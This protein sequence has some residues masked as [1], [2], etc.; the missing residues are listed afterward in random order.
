MRTWMLEAPGIENLALKE[1]DTPEPGP[2]QVRLRMTAACVNFR[3]TVIA[4]TGNGGELPLVP[5]SDGAGVIDAVGEGVTRVAVGDRV[6]PL[7]FP[8]WEGGRFT[9]EHGAAALG[10]GQDGVLREQMV[11]SAEGVVKIPDYMSD[12]EAAT[13]P[14]AGLTAW[15]TLVNAAGIKP[16][17]IVTLQGTGG[18]SIYA[19]QFAK[20]AG[21]EVIITS[22]S[23]EK[24]ARARQMG[25]DHTINY[26]DNPDWSKN[27]LEITGGAGADI[28]VEVG[29][30]DT[31][32]QSLEAV[33]VSGFVGVIG[34]LSGLESNLSVMSI[35]GKGVRVQGIYVGSRQMQE[36]M[37]RA[38]AATQMQPV[39]SD[40]VSFE[41]A[42]DAY[43]LMQ[44]QGHFGKIVIDYAA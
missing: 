2:G 31:I 5:L 10:G 4:A 34:I 27:V 25:A 21:A 12:V 1:T 42:P 41:N 22:S 24:L 37:V 44:A 14:C 28:V 26:K 13:L 39:I 3:D 38:M 30:A 7:F 32:A 36:D 18:V 43:R 29:G 11:I 19:L 23:D 20:M 40:S 33:A 17:D 6:T 15:H 8:T 16:G 35:L 9:G